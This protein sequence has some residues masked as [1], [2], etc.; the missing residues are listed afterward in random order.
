[1][2]YKNRHVQRVALEDGESVELSSEREEEYRAVEELVETPPLRDHHMQTQTQT[3]WKSQGE[4]F[5]EEYR[6]ARPVFFTGPALPP[7]NLEALKSEHEK[8]MWR[9][10]AQSSVDKVNRLPFGLKNY[11]NDFL[12]RPENEGEAHTH[13]FSRESLASGENGRRG[14]ALEAIEQIKSDGLG[15]SADMDDSE[16]RRFLVRSGIKAELERQKQAFFKKDGPN[17][18]LTYF[19]SLSQHTTSEDENQQ[20]TGSAFSLGLEYPLGN[21]I[22][23]LGN[24]SL[25]GGLFV[26]SNFYDI[27]EVN[28]LFGEQSFG[29]F[30]RW[31]F[32]DPPNLV[33]RFIPYVGVGWRWGQAKVSDADFDVVPG[34]L[35]YFFVALPSFQLGG[36]YRF[37]AGD[38]EWNPTGLGFGVNFQMQYER[39]VFENIEVPSEELYTNFGTNH[40]NLGFGVN[41]YF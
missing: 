4:E 41:I 10:T 3:A 18:N 30:G 23:S 16:L 12:G 7:Q 9:Y 1:M 14:M 21:S 40:L 33:K 37:Q 5:D 8:A 6:G 34:N 22:A 20:G 11:Y 24:Y 19:S 13:N 38:E 15:F 36:K 29:L 32:R 27:G 35:N 2:S 39:M 31:Y 28:A 25:Q 17:V 26:G